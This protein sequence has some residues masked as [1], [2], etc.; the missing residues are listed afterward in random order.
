MIRMSGSKKEL[1]K[2]VASTAAAAAVGAL[3][4]P[5]AAGLAAVP[6]MIE[7]VVEATSA[8]RERRVRVWLEYV[9]AE[10]DPGRL[11][12]QLRDGL[13]SQRP[14]VVQAVVG[15]ARAVADAVDDNAI[16][17]IAQLTRM[18]VIGAVPRWFHRQALEA[19]SNLD[20]AE[21]SDL[22]KL[23]D[24][25][26]VTGGADSDSVLARAERF[27]RGESSTIEFWRR[28]RGTVQKGAIEP[29]ELLHAFHLFRVLVVSGLSDDAPDAFMGI[30][31]STN[32]QLVHMDR[33]TAEM[34]KA[35]LDLSVPRNE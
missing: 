34:L 27:E 30:V 12:E 18:C 8:F 31:G 11:S 4:G 35:V 13:Q 26:S 32:R 10:P 24:G 9:L 16:P 28:A 15:G 20:G 14:E 17:P 5:L 22:R 21:L 23:V 6:G 1:A 33:R 3:A 2:G 29:L 19:L 7:I 25:L